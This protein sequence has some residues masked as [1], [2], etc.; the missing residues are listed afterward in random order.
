M[1]RSDETRRRKGDVLGL[2]SAA[3][4]EPHAE[5]TSRDPEEQRKRRERM[6]EDTDQVTTGTNDLV[7]GSGAASTDMGAGGEGTDVER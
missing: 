1:D 6:R 4:S 3:G 2:G 5:H 7:R